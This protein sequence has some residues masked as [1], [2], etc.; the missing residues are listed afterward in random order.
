L[1]RQCLHPKHGGCPK[2]RSICDQAIRRACQL[3]APAIAAWCATAEAACSE[4]RRADGL[5][6][7]QTDAA[8]VNTESGWQDVKIGVFAKRE[9]GEPTT[10][11]RLEVDGRHG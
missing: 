11:T 8:E 5:P 3:E 6:E 1:S 7:F 4:F 2:E 9:A 10:A